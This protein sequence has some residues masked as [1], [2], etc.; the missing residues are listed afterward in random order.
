MIRKP[1]SPA[2]HHGIVTP[3]QPPPHLSECDVPAPATVEE[4]SG[5]RTHAR[6]MRKLECVDLV[7]RVTDF[8]EGSLDAD[9]QS[10]LARH[11]SLCWACANYV[12]EMNTTV[13]L[14][15]Q[16]PPERLSDQLWSNLSMMYRQWA[17]EVRV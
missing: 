11:I 13:Q 12:G 16:L 1:P 5:A 10:Q 2:R 6:P 17:A 3:A 9:T 7:E 15:S 14:M 8:M 4:C